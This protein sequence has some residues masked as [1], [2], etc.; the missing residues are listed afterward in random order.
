[1]YRHANFRIGG[2]NRKA[3]MCLLLVAVYLLQPFQ[4]KFDESVAATKRSC[5]REIITTDG[6]RNAEFVSPPHDFWLAC[7]I[8]ASLLRPTR[9]SGCCKISACIPDGVN[10]LVRLS[11]MRAYA[12]CVATNWRCKA[13]YSGNTPQLMPTR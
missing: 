7:S 12:E 4:Y 8:V 13:G 5:V 9:V 11:V 6:Q 3:D 10:F 1:M 2:D